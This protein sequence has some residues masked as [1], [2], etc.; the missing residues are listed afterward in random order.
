MINKINIFTKINPLIMEHLENLAQSNIITTPKP[1]KYKGEQRYRSQYENFILSR[2]DRFLRIF[3]S[4]P[5]YYQDNDLA[6][7][8]KE[9]VENAF[10]KLE[11]ALGFDIPKFEIQKVSIEANLEVDFKPEKVLNQRSKKRPV[12]IETEYG[13]LIMDDKKE[14]LARDKKNPVSILKQAELPLDS[15]FVKAELVMKKAHLKEMFNTRMTVKNLLEKKTYSLL[16]SHWSFLF[17][18][19]LDPCHFDVSSQ[20]Q[21]KNYLAGIGFQ[22]MGYNNLSEYLEYNENSDIHKLDRHRM[23]K[24]IDQ[25][26]DYWEYSIELSNKIEAVAKEETNQ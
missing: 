9:S 11:K 20:G 24:Y 23:K 16:V 7:L 14:E 10:M 13:D 17:E 8:T 15:N 18:E 12:K 19:F 22:T 6:F 25:L 5:E 4:L 26:K 21:L 3:G 2:S 1:K